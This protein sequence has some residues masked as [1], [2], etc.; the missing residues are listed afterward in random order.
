MSFN[1]QKSVYFV[2]TTCKHHHHYFETDE[3]KHIL[4]NAIL[5]CNALHDADLIGYVIMPNHIHLLLRIRNRDK[6]IKYMHSLKT[7]AS[8]AVRHTLILR[9]PVNALILAYHRKRQTYKVWEDGYH[10][11]EVFSTEFLIQKLDYIHRNPLQEKWK[12]VERAE[13]Y[14][15]SSAGF[16]MTGLRGVM[17]VVHFNRY[18]EPEV[19][20][21]K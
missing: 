13:D 5:N 15:Y 7:Y 8:A 18:F 2:T 20:W 14:L 12:M 9:D 10:W 19:K 3:V 4:C 16:Y 1:E 17:E 21:V 11:K 6:L